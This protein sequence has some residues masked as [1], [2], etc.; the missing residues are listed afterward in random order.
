[1]PAT[2]ALGT[3]LGRAW[4]LRCPACGEGPV[5]ARGFR[6][7]EECGACGRRLDLDEG[8]W[9]GGAEVLIAVSW[10][11]G[12][13]VLVPIALFAD[14]PDGAVHLLAAVHLGFSLAIYRTSRA[15]FL[16]LDFAVDPSDD[17]PP[18]PP[19][20]DGDGAEPAPA[21]APAPGEARP[22]RSRARP[23]RASV[24]V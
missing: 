4:R 11:F 17:R 3:L 23:L 15:V 14:L 22:P 18:E 8:H 10:G 19:G 24:S 21:P 9:L 12:C 13:L 2:V 7:A 6:R 5:F 1:M 20:D 16:A